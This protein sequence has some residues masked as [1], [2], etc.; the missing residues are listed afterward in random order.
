MMVT[1]GLAGTL[2]AGLLGIDGKR[3]AQANTTAEAKQAE[4]D[5]VEKATRGQVVG[6][7]GNPVAGATVVAWRMSLAPNRIDD[8][9]A[10]RS[11]VV[12]ERKK[13]GGDGRYEFNFETPELAAAARVLATAPG[14]GLG[15]LGKDGQIRLSEG[16][17]PIEGRLVDLEGRPV[18]GVKV[19]LGQ[20]MLPQAALAEEATSPKRLGA[21]LMKMPATGAGAPRSPESRFSMAGRLILDAHPLYPDG[22]VTDS[23]GRFR[24]EG[25]GR[26]VMVNL[27]LSGP[28]IASKQVRVLTRA[29]NRQDEQPR[30]PSFQGLGEPAIHGRQMHDRR[31]A[32]SANRGVCP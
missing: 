27:T 25:L 5:P 21:P 6:P 8:Q 22:V 12:I 31:R 23:E 28:T 32:R 24:I 1:V 11:P 26:D 19:S 3:T 29:M 20:V 9:H 17:L 7:A 16:D 13:T 10:A 30:D 18:E 4:P 15:H 14:F 2:L